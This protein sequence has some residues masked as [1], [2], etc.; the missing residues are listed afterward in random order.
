MLSALVC[1]CFCFVL[2][3][4]LNFK[5]PGPWYAWPISEL[6][7]LQGVPWKPSLKPLHQTT[8]G[9]FFQV[10]RRIHG[11]FGRLL[12]AS[13][14]LGVK[15]LPVLVTHFCDSSFF[16]QTK[17]DLGKSSESTAS[18]WESS[19]DCTTW[20]F[21][22]RGLRPCIFMIMA[23]SPWSRNPNSSNTGSK[24]DGRAKWLHGVSD[25]TDPNDIPWSNLPFPLVYRLR[26]VEVWVL[27]FWKMSVSKGH[28][29]TN[30]LREWR[31]KGWENLQR[32]SPQVL[33]WQLFFWVD[34][35][36]AFERNSSQQFG[37]SFFI[38]LKQSEAQ[39][40]RQTCFL[41]LEE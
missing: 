21:G 22:L 25:W 9:S 3:V 29:L 30:W 4:F 41:D 19:F 23:A 34:G 11:G 16:P 32:R 5:S 37:F 38:D 18:Q 40:Q 17:I 14:F 10:R 1:F 15:T 39:N 33:T 8:H 35:G 31:H 6:I 24:G 26:Q 28:H 2:C 7:C 12:P 27:N 20:L 13:I 36:G